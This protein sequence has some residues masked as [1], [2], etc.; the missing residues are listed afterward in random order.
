[1]TTLSALMSQIDT[2]LASRYPETMPEYMHARQGALVALLAV[3]LTGPRTPQQVFAGF[4]QDL[5]DETANITPN[6]D[7]I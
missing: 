5:T 4:L 1:M 6:N 3:I 7:Q 2:A